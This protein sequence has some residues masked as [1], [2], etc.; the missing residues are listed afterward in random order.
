MV[1][2]LKQLKKLC[3]WPIL[4]VFK[5]LLAHGMFDCIRAANGLRRIKALDFSGGILDQE[6]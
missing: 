5:L 1:A 3:F 4:A 2:A 6:R